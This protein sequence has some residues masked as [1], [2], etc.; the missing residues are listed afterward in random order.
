MTKRAPLPSADVVET[1]GAA[2]V[3]LREHVDALQ[4]ATWEALNAD[5]GSAAQATTKARAALKR[6]HAA[7]DRF[8]EVLDRRKRRKP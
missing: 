3:E 7:L 8:G 4:A 2:H 6:A 1:Y 5:P